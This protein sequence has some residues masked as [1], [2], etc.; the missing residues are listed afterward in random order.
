MV[1]V[2][3]TL[4]RS[5]NSSRL[6][7]GTFSTAGLHGNLDSALVA[8][9]PLRQVGQKVGDV[10]PRMSV[11]AGAQS[12][13]IQEMCNQTDTA[14]QD[15]QTVQNTHAEIV[16]CLFGREGAAVA[17]QV[18][19]ADSNAAVDVQDQVV[20]LGSGDGLDGDGVIKK[21]VGGEVFDNKFF[22]ELNTEI[23]VGARLD[24]V[25]N[26]GDCGEVSRQLLRK[27]Q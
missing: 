5:P 7:S 9:C 8:R 1:K 22:D 3:L 12:L 25:T 20:F 16:L 14:S 21:L 10:V 11:Q 2:H 24:A 19:E 23:G 6:K 27:S 18:D 17:Q 4:V 15:E 13:L 26:T